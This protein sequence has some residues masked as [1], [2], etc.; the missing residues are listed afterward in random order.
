MNENVKLDIAIEIMSTKIAMA[1]ENKNQEEV[2][3]LLDE[4]EQL[5]LGNW[6]IINKIID[7]YSVD[8]KR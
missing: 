8:V 4:R 1:M 3:K 5:Y 2:N 6:E 7:Q